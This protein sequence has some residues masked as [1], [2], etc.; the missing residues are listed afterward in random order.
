MT[1]K[2]NR[3]ARPEDGWRAKCND[4]CEAICEF[5]EQPLDEF[6]ESL[7]HVDCLNAYLAR[8]KKEATPRKAGSSRPSNLEPCYMAQVDPR[9]NWLWTIHDTIRQIQEDVPTQEET[10]PWLDKTT[11]SCRRR[12]LEMRHLAEVTNETPCEEYN[13]DE[14]QEEEKPE[15][16]A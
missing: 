12:R 9:K 15:V 6:D 11:T 16:I 4:C 5:C 3:K 2:T 1:G 8:D 13:K 14:W 10:L 7:Y